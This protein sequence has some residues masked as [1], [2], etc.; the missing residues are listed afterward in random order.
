MKFNKSEYSILAIFAI[1]Y[2]VAIFRYQTLP[3]YTLLATGLFA[4]S[5]ICWGILHQSRIHNLNFR[6][7][8]EYFLVAIL[9]VAIVSTLLI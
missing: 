9:G 7:M 2:I 1:I 6:I 8:L 3:S 4:F 5:Y